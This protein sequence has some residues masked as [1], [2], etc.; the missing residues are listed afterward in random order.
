MRS[1]R[2]QVAGGKEDEVS[3]SA[4]QSEGCIMSSERRGE[5][6]RSLAAAEHA[7][8]RLHQAAKKQYSLQAAIVPQDV[9]GNN[10]HRMHMQ[11]EWAW[12]IAGL[13]CEEKEKTNLLKIQYRNTVWM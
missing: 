2:K 4:A 3:I 11:Q 5:S 9:A 10:K 6:S 8:A 12:G 13:C 1:K 7:Y